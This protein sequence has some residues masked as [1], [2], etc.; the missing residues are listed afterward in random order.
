MVPC[1]IMH[2]DCV[3]CA[4]KRCSTRW[5]VSTYNGYYCIS[6]P[7]L[8]HSIVRK[9]ALWM[10][11]RSSSYL[12]LLLWFCHI[13]FIWWSNVSCNICRGTLNGPQICIFN[14]TS[15]WNA[16][17]C[18]TIQ[19]MLT[20]IFDLSL[21]TVYIYRNVVQNKTEFK[22][23]CTEYVPLS[24]KKWD[25]IAHHHIFKHS[26]SINVIHRKRKKWYSL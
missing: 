18:H 19:S 21:Q 12:I 2:Q 9:C 14:D 13:K 16:F 6:L 17:F 5:A 20:S 1:L 25:P 22:T 7:I 26:K 10:R 11:A 24:C 23:R 3:H 4:I 8:L 15:L